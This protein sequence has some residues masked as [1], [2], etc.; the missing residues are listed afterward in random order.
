MLFIWIR[1]RQ[2]NKYMHLICRQRSRIATARP[3]ATVMDAEICF[4]GWIL[5]VMFLSLIRFE[6]NG[7]ANINSDWSDLVVWD[8]QQIGN[9]SIW[10][11]L[12]SQRIILTI[13]TFDIG[14]TVHQTDTFLHAS[15]NGESVL[16]GIHWNRIF[17]AH[18]H[19]IH[20]RIDVEE[21]EKRIKIIK[22]KQQQR[23][24]KNDRFA[25]PLYKMKYLYLYNAICM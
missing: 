13:N 25:V 1:L 6:P 21:F 10:M 23:S 24:G 17:S 12:I 8:C 7:M 5:I 20:R 16:N 22:K 11:C 4:G 2:S 14:N 9:R 18:R 19:F 15:V 3:S